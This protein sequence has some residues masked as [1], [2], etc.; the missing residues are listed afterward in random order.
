[1]SHDKRATPP[2]PAWIPRAGLRIR[3]DRTLAVGDAHFRWHTRLDGT[4]L[5]HG[6]AGRLALGDTVTMPVGHLHR[7]GEVPA[8]HYVVTHLH[9]DEHGHVWLSVA[10]SPRGG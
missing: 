1:V 6:P 7:A 9:E 8:V 10:R 5:L 4:A 2:P 3:W